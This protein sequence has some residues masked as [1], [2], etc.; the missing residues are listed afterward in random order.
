MFHR[1]KR[2]LNNLLN[3]VEPDRR[4]GKSRFWDL[5]RVTPLL[6]SFDE[7]SVATP[8]KTRKVEEEV[9]RLCLQNDYKA[10]IL[11][12][13]SDVCE[14]L[15]R[16]MGRLRATLEQKLLNEYPSAVAGLEPEQARVYG[17]RLFDEIVAEFKRA[18]EEWKS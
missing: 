14:S 4:I 11:V 15:S 13:R 1:D 12:K 9:R 3:R 16:I 18:G 7:R 6:Q 2:T 5:K 8:V 10:G 17:R